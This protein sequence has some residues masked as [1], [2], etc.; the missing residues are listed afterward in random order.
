[1]SN[2]KPR[3]ELPERIN[4]FAQKLMGYSRPKDPRRE[5]APIFAGFQDRVIA[6]VLDTALV[7]LLFQDVFRY[8]SARIYRLA[9]YELLQRMRD[10]APDSPDPIIALRHAVDA[11]FASG[12][13]Q[14]WLLNS[15][16][17]SLVVGALLIFCWKEFH[18]TPGKYIIGLE[19]A[20]RNG[21][22]KPTF[23]QYIIRFLGFYI[24]MPVFMLGFAALAFDKQ[25]RAVHDRIAGT[26]V[27]Y[28]Q[29]G[30]IFRQA[31]DW[32]KQ[33]MKKR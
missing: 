12:L 31:W 3:D 6:S 23:R 5:D 20:G 28:S 13:A 11:A 32:I 7:F 24:S 9:D 26:T 17:Q 8:V 2:E 18:L 4:R 22:G 29:R 21:Q 27:I 1:M 30:S 14:L 16:L 25:K 33:A 19:F 15:F 10:A